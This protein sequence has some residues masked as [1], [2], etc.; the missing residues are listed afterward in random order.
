M[1][2]YEK[3][4]KNRVKLTIEVDSSIF[5]EALSNAYIKTKNRFNVPGFRK[6]KAPRKMIESMYGEG[7]FYE[8]A[9][10]LVYN[11][12]YN[13]AVEEHNLEPVDRPELSIEQI[14]LGETLIF[15]AE[16]DVKPEVVL[17]DYKGIEVVKREYT[18]EE[19]E[20]DNVIAQERQ[21]V[22]R[23]VEVDGAVENGHRVV[24]DYSGSVDGVK[25]DGGTAEDQNLE[26]GSGTFIPGF[27]EQLI[28]L[29]KD[30]EKDI[31][32]TFPEEYHAEEL[33]GKEAVFA[34][35]IKAIQKEELPELDDEFAQEISEFDTLDE[36][37]ADKRAQLE[38]RN[39]ERAQSEMEDEAVR[40]ATA[41]ATFDMPRAITERQMDYMLQDIAYRLST[42][43]LSLDQYCQ[44]MGM[45]SRQLRESYREEAEQRARISLVLEAIQKAESIEA[46]EDEVEK[47]IS[48]YAERVGQD[49][50]EIKKT[51]RDEDMDYF[52]DRIVNGKTITL[53]FES[54]VL[55][56][57]PA[58]ETKEEAADEA[59]EKEELAEEK[60]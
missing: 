52:K 17:G 15:T 1:A 55:V 51:L 56:D 37:R 25:F 26:I 10:D 30:E 36:L 29:K 28:G 24:L 40:K 42:S 58:E 54:A 49:V 9:F 38:K 6:G 14:G 41:N 20:V 27:E 7:V 13:A 48:D 50:E 12:A 31:T 43:G 21:K 4:E 33:K 44:Y 18:V 2:T 53:L 16:V 59:N 39:S 57:A 5:D 22:A 11:D 46:T 34:V 32:V 19:T 8:D 45:D 35:K 23:I 3:L 60:E 47:E